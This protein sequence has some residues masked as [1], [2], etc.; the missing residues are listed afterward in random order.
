MT[1]ICGSDGWYCRM[2][3]LRCAIQPEKLIVLPQ[4]PQ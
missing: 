1:D 2:W 4:L 3:L